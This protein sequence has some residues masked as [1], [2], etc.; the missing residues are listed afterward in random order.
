ML[1]NKTS[2]SSE[3]PTHRNEAQPL[4][5]ETEGRLRS[6][7]DPAQPN[8]NLFLKK[9]SLVDWVKQMAF[10]NG[11][12]NLQFIEDLNKKADSFLS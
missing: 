7:E 4:L 2:C 10:P 11:W 5:P 1:C 8:I 6:N 12:V 9:I 3:K